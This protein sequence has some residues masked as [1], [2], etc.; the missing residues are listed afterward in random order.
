MVFR[1]V[2]PYIVPQM[3]SRSMPRRLLLLF[4]VLWT[5]GRASALTVGFDALGIA[6]VS[7]APD[8]G[9]KIQLGGNLA[10]VF[11]FSLVSW[12]DLAASVEG[13]G[14]LP[15]DVSGGFAYRGFGG[16]ALGTALEAHFPLAHAERLGSLSAG[17]SLGG[18]GALPAYASTS[19]YFFYLEARLGGFLTWEPAGTRGLSVRLGIPAR[20]DLRRDMSYS[21][22]TGLSLGIAYELAGAR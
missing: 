16:G 2:P 8:F 1:A 10:A 3:G 18:A 5:T 4:L 15:S 20:A 11:T 7:A 14:M 19:L 6:Q 9:P 12:L 21:L 22:S 13:F 17:L